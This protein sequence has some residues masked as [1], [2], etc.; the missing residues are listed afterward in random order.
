MNRK[1]FLVTRIALFSALVYVLSYGT[2]FFPNV[3]LV[4]FIVFSSGFLWGAVPGILVGMIGM[5]LWTM[6]N[7]FGPAALPIMIAQVGGAGLSGVVG[8]AFRRSDWEQISSSKRIF[9]LI[10][11][12]I[13]CTV[14]YFLP[15]NIVDAWMW[16]PFEE[17]FIGGA[18]WALISVCSNVV[19]F[20]LLFYITLKLYER[21]GRLR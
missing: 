11:S 2:S 1:P 20:P 14:F 16:G 4:F 13:L 8:A 5:G 12:A 18:F 10:I 3:N 9:K 7:P 19:I 6:F 17:R 21:E 15:V